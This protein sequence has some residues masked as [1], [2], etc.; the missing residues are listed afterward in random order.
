MTDE[1]FYNKYD[2]PSIN[3]RFIQIYNN[4]TNINNKKV[5]LINFYY[6]K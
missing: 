1:I 6:K 5:L 3:E 2:D 4:L